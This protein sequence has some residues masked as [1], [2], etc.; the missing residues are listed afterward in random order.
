MKSII[1]IFGLLFL[2]VLGQAQIIEE[3][4]AQESSLEAAAEAPLPRVVVKLKGGSVLHGQLVSY[5]PEV[6]ILVRINGS[7]ILIAEDKIQ[8]FV[9]KESSSA[10]TFSRLKTK[11]I[12]YRTSL[13]TLS[14]ED[15]A[16]MCLNISALYQFNNYISA[17]VGMGIDNY[18]FNEPHNMYPVFAEIKTYLVDRKSSPFVSLKT[19]YSFNTPHEESG[20]LIARGGLLINPTFG[21]RFGTRGIMFD[22]YGGYRFQEAYYEKINWNGLSQQEILWKRIELGLALSF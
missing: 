2:S 9:T 20:Q 17:G 12:Y 3:S 10:N 22:I 15:G 21:Y 16:G 8:K 1:L 13:A 19:G 6:G 4:S 18:Y 11:K 14:N 5:Q 7:D